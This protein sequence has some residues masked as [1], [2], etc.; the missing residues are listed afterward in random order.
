MIPDEN[1][2]KRLWD[3]YL[4]PEPKRV[5]AEL[6]ARVASFFVRE[7]NRHIP[8][9]NANEALV[10][11]GGLLHDIDKA[12]VKREGER[13]PDTAVRILRQEGMDEV[14]DLV[15][16]HPLHAI[17][18]PSICPKTWEEKLLYLADKMVKYEIITVDKR[19]ALWNEEHLPQ[20]AQE[21]L[22]R[23]YPEVKKLE[24]E[25]FGF[26]G[27]EPQEVAKLALV[28]YTKPA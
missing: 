12:V 20:E 3:K 24:K 15:V 9:A 1:Q 5:H 25:I 6:V 18:D 22:D 23:C 26:I 21:M 2:A 11:A 14:A 4:L 17:V 13:H 19:F 7:C 28:G 27:V 8:G 10:I 16:T